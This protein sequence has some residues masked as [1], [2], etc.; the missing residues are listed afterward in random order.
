MDIQAIEKIGNDAQKRNDRE[1]KINKKN[2]NFSLRG[3][4]KYFYASRNTDP[5]I[6]GKPAKYNASLIY[7]N[8]PE[9]IKFV[10]NDYREV[11][12]MDFWFFSNSEYMDKFSKI[13]DNLDDLNQN[14]TASDR[15]GLGYMGSERVVVLHLNNIG[16]E[17]ENIRQVFHRTRDYELVRRWYFNSLY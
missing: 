10:E 4:N 6:R 5:L 7:K 17:K 15:D 12:M 14:C 13:Y 8:N 3:H 9:K 1:F 16:I 11:G 2:I